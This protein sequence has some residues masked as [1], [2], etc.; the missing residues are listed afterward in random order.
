MESQ[1]ISRVGVIGSGVMGHGIAM[2]FAKSG[3]TVVMTD[4]SEDFLRSG[5]EAISSGRFGLQRLV[6]KGTITQQEKEAVLSRISTSTDTGD[7]KDCDLIVEAAPEDRKIKGE[8]FGALD[9]I[10]KPETIFASN[11]SGI[12]IS[13]LASFTSRGSQ[14]VGMHWF[15]PPQVMK[16]VEI[17]R[18]PETS[19]ET[20]DSITAVSEKMAKVP[21]TV[22]DGPGFFTTRFIDSWLMEAYRIFE[23]GVA[24]VKEIDQMSKL[25]FGFPMGP[26]ELSDLIGLDTMLHVADYMFEET[27]DPAYAAPVILKKMVLSGYLG[28]KKGSKGGWYDYYGL[29][30]PGK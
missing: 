11:T 15:N 2:S 23:Q 4:I 14:F 17:V 26:F 10:C 24:G 20:L 12:M 7:L 29:E 25:A 6:D 5:M 16:L 30:P 27:K 21:V 19:Q 28:K 1:N 13:D 22:N 9:R 3:Y 18:G 8:I